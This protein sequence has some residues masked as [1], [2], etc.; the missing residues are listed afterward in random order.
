MMAALRRRDFLFGSA[1]L[2]GSWLLPVAS[3]AAAPRVVSLDYGLAQTLIEIGAPPVGLIDT[4][5]WYDWVMEPT[6]PQGV[7]N[8]GSNY[9]INMEM[10]QLLQ[11]DL[12]VTTP[13]LEWI[14]PQ[15]EKIAPV[16]SFPIHALGSPPYPHI[17]AATTELGRLLGRAQA[18]QALIDRTERDLESAKAA[19]RRLAE[20][21]LAIITFLDARNIRVYGPGGIFQDVLDRIELQNAWTRKTNEWGFSDAGLA[22]LIALGD[23]HVFYM[24]PV[25][26][27]V[28]AGLDGSPLWQ[29]MPFVQ[30]GHVQRMASVL[31]FGALPSISRFARLLAEVKV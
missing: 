2:A 25:P 24:D 23:S 30:K 19:T 28:L 31:M 11:P 29:A 22:D 3:S 6:L 27:D 21:K 18:A 17:V 15:L 8:V 16:Q 5:G 1:A 9:E 10:L 7:A 4:Q 26:P 14:R 20:Q 12:I 13:Y